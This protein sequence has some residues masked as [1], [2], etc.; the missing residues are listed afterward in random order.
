VSAFHFE[1]PG[2][3][4]DLDDTRG[5][6]ARLDRFRGLQPNLEITSPGLN[7]LGVWQADWEGAD[8]RRTITRKHAA[9]LL[10]AM[11]EHFPEWEPQD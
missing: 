6:L 5:T 7:G 10:D 4:S 1:V 2:A 11:R 9:D 8:G 3:H